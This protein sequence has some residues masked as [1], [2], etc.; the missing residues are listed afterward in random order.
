MRKH[1]ELGA[2]ILEGANLDDIA[3]WVLAHHERPDGQGY[4]LG[5]AADQ[6]PLQ[7]RILAV[8]DAY[9]AMTND[10][11]YRPA[12]PETE[13]R[14]ELARY[15]GT[16]FDP[17]VV[18]ALREAAR[19]GG[20]L[21][22]VAWLASLEGAAMS[23]HR[24]TR[25]RDFLARG[26]YRGADM[27]V[28]RRVTACAAFLTA[29]VIAVPRTAVAARRARRRA[30]RLVGSLRRRRRPRPRRAA[31]RADDR[32]Q[33]GHG[34][35]AP[36]RGACVCRACRVA[37]G[38]ARVAVHHALPA[39]DG[40]RGRFPSA[41][42]NA[43]DHRGVRCGLACLPF[44]YDDWS[45]VFAGDMALRLVIWSALTM[46]ACIWTTR[47]RMQRADLMAGRGAGQAPG[48]ARPAD[49]PRQPARVRRAA[50]PRC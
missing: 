28:V 11:V 43:G 29:L 9:E 38:W 3:G 45:G 19:A 25:V 8:A 26:G 30:D 2:R 44:F 37:L 5:L 34:A 39:L 20:A 47:V 27:D 13:A 33:A 14:A 15:A 35:R 22:R 24:V 18:A 49:R 1:P 50:R 46:M 21:R 42:P 16:Q 31:A 48:A 41:A 7:A 6:I 40:H 17:E 12:M 23:A 32:V 36:L 4:P 10:R